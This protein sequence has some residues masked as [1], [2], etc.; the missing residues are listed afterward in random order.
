MYDTTGKEEYLRIQRQRTCLPTSHL[1]IERLP[2]Q[3]HALATSCLAYCTHATE[4]TGCTHTS[5][6]RRRA[7][8]R[9][10]VEA[11]SQRAHKG[12]WLY[13][14]EL[15]H[16]YIQPKTV[17][18]VYWRWGHGAGNQGKRPPL[19]PT[20]AIPHRLAAPPKVRPCLLSKLQERKKKKRFSLVLR[21]TASIH[22]PALSRPPRE[23]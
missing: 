11:L 6:S 1:P 4:S 13:E 12:R 23:G 17:Y 16:A 2:R 15:V 22:P 18:S 21:R 3:P 8:L 5:S 9:D 20:R 7:R 14:C 10:K 19:S